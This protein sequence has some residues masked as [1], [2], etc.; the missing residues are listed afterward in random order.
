[1]RADV[2]ASIGALSSSV[3]RC[4]GRRSRSATLTTNGSGFILVEERLVLARVFRPRQRRLLG[5]RQRSDAQ[6]L[7]TR[8]DGLHRPLEDDLEGGQLLVAVV[9]GLVLEAVRD[10]ACILHGVTG[11]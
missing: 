3:R 4:P 1:G 10:V 11:D 5:R 6:L 2:S 8:L 9:L 7:P